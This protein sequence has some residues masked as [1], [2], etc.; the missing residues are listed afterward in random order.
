MWPERIEPQEIGTDRL[1]VQ[2]IEARE[3]LLSALSLDELA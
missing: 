3:A 2:V 1:A